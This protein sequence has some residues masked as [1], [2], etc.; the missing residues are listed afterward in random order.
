MD[1]FNEEDVALFEFQFT[2]LCPLQ[3]IKIRAKFL[4]VAIKNV[5]ARMFLDYDFET[6]LREIKHVVKLFV[7]MHVPIRKLTDVQMSLSNTETVCV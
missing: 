5:D 4:F 1:R 2:C 7:L 6:S 3:E